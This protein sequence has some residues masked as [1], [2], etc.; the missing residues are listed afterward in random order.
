MC[1]LHTYKK[2]WTDI[3]A[4]YTTPFVHELGPGGPTRG[5]RAAQLRGQY[6]M[7]ET[8]APMTSHLFASHYKEKQNKK[9]KGW[10]LQK[11]LAL[12][13]FKMEECSQEQ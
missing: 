8:H 11:I 9:N 13:L 3:N 1:T 7:L 6:S 4:L 10:S 5:Y 12:C 2:Y